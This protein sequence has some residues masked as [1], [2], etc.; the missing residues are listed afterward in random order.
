MCA[1]VGVPSVSTIAS[2]SAA[3][4]AR[5][6]TS[7]GVRESSS[8]VPGSLNGIRCERTA[9]SRSAS[10]S[11]PS[12]RRPASANARASGRPTRPSPMTA[13]S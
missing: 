4:V 10:L 1:N 11:I 7:S 2:D 12:T 3:S 9:S 13:T 8:S 5:A 6:E